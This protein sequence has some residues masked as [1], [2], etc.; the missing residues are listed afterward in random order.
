MCHSKY[1]LKILILSITIIYESSCVGID[2]KIDELIE[3]SGNNRGEMRK[4]ALHFSRTPKDSLKFLAFLFLFENMSD[5]IS[6]SGAQLNSFYSFV[7]SLS[8]KCKSRLEFEAAVGQFKENNKGLVGQLSLQKDID[9]IS[10]KFLIQN[11]Q[12]SFEAYEN[13]GFN[14]MVNFETFCEYVLP[15]KLGNETNEDFRSLVLN[16]YKLNGHKR[17]NLVE[18]TNCL[19]D[20]LSKAPIQ[21]AQFPDFVPDFPASDLINLRFGTCNESSALAAYVMRS[22]GIPVAIDFTPQWGQ[23]SGAHSWCALILGKDSCVDFEGSNSQKVGGHL[24]VGRSN[25]LAK[26]YRRTFSSQNNSLAAIH[27]DEEIPTLFSNAH[28]IDV[29]SSYFKG[30]NIGLTVPESL[31]GGKKIGYLCVF[32]NANWQPIAWSSFS[33]E[34]ICFKN[35]GKNVVYL[36]AIYEDGEIMAIKN[37]I[38]LD[39]AGSIITLNADKSNLMHVKLLRKYPIMDWWDSRTLDMTNGTFQVS[40]DLCFKN[41][42]E[43][44][45]IRSSPALKFNNA[46]VRLKKKYRYARYLA[47][48]KSYGEIAELEFYSFGKKIGGIPMSSFPEDSILYNA[49]MA[50]DNNNLTYFQGKGTNDQ[51]WIGI[52]FREPVNLT[53]IR[54]LGRND[55][56]FINESDLYELFFWDNGSWNSLG[57]KQ[58]KGNSQMLEYDNVPSNALLLLRDYSKGKEERIF[59]YQKDNQV[60]W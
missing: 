9:V 4:A 34:D 54:F 1:L 59:T 15:Y 58:S 18:A 22:N 44:Y 16:K 46:K 43:V 7:D 33:G 60:W 48:Q 6:Y 53:E 20:T 56:N 49:E 13:N 23:R 50:F 35:L 14:T 5:K 57:K 2:Q 31:R 51:N 19:L 3:K 8:L 27:G 21:L 41:P 47:P 30:C 12:L 37:P 29:S 36:P 45:R 17:Y 28:I 39:S 32:D 40:N 25:R 42:V 11:I 24:L 38:L 55:D 26:I 52:D 10:S